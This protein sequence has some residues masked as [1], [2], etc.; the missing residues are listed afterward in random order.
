MGPGSL[1]LTVTLLPPFPPVTVDASR[2]SRPSSTVTVLAPSPRCHLDRAVFDRVDGDIVDSIAR[3]QRD[4][5][6]GAD[7][8]VQ[9][10]VTLAVVRRDGLVAEQSPVQ[11]ST[12]SVS[13]P[14]PSVTCTVRPSVRP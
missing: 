7:V 1:V 5:G 9:V 10:V 14:L 3:R 13:L 4:G 2:P 8:H 12:L 11:L 6:I